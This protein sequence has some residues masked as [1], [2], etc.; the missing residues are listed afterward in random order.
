MLKQQHFLFPY[1]RQMYKDSYTNLTGG[2][3]TV[4]YKQD[5]ITLLMGRK[6]VGWRLR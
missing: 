5:Y 3:S 2:S 6:Y 1:S 4:L